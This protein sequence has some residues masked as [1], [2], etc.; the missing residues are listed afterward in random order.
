MARLLSGSV[1]ALALLVLAF[2]PAAAGD[3]ACCEAKR[4][5]KEQRAAAA[6]QS[7]EIPDPL[8][9]APAK[10]VTYCFAQ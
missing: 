4:K 10:E 9:V 5:L 3:E 2:A 8:D 7:P 1:A 6:S